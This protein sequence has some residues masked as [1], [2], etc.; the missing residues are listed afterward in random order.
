VRLETERLVLRLPEP[1]DAE[2]YAAVW[3]D[4]E[5]VRFLSG[6]LWTVDD[7]RHAID[8]MRR[9]WE[10]FGLGLFSVVRNEDERVLGRVGF[11]V[12]DPKRWVNGHGEK[13]EPPVETEVGWTL[14]REY[15]NRGYATEAA[16]ACRDLALG[17]LGL[18]RLISL[19]A[20]GNQASVRVAE[21]IGEHFEREVGDGFFPRRVDL[22][23]LEAGGQSPAR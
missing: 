16:L 4:P 6:K 10:W 19:I 12:W 18:T 2:S 13:L 11:L 7:A 14:G 3:S 17:E 21:K 20:R 22:Y 23:S 1:A 9:H 15:W 5:V 8:R